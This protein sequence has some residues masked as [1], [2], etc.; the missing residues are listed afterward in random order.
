MCSICFSGRPSQRCRRRASCF[1]ELAD[2]G[3]RLQLPEGW[4]FRSYV[5]AEEFRLPSVDGVAEVVTDD[6]ANTYQLIPE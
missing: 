1:T 5:L 2:L 6:L 3:G 4:R